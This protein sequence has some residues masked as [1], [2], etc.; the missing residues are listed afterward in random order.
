MRMR[1]VFPE[2]PDRAV[3][4]ARCQS[5]LDPLWV[6]PNTNGSRNWGVFQIS[7]VRLAELGG[8]PLLAYDPDWNIRAARRLW[9]VRQ[10]FRDWP[11]CDAAHAGASSSAR[12]GPARPSSRVP[13]V[14][15]SRQLVP[16]V[17]AQ[18][19]PTQLRLPALWGPMVT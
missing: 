3:A 19:P 6:L 5:C 8:T 2:E 16:S 13:P 11:A 4:S 14:D 17:H 12:P 10:D 1:A 7:D 15:P 9:A 18:A